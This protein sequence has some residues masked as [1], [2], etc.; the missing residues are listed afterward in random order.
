M[1]EALLVPNIRFFSEHKTQAVDFH[2]RVMNVHD[3]VADRTKEVEFD[4]CI[5]ADGSHSVVR[6]QLMRV[7]RYVLWIPYAV[8]LSL[9]R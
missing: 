7:T 9:S 5:G 6:R 3:V 2:R 4:L 1:E 8:A